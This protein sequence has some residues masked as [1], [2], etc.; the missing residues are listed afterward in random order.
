MRDIITVIKFFPVEIIVIM[1]VMG[2]GSGPGVWAGIPFGMQVILFGCLVIGLLRG[3]YALCRVG[4]D[5]EFA[6]SAAPDFESEADTVD[7]WK[8]V[9]DQ[10]VAAR[11]FPPESPTFTAD[12]LVSLSKLLDAVNVLCQDA[13][14]SEAEGHALP[15]GVRQT[16]ERVSVALTPECSDLRRLAA[17]LSRG[18][19]S[20]DSPMEYDPVWSPASP[21]PQWQAALLLADLT[22]AAQHLASLTTMLGLDGAN[23]FLAH[24]SKVDSIRNPYGLIEINPVTG[25]WPKVPPV[26]Y[27]QLVGA[28]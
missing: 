19:V 28:R 6:D 10:M 22:Q 18:V 26:D 9:Q 11:R 15:D 1:L 8:I 14:Y 12:A 16:L 2:I 24:A 5:E 21:M 17:L 7:P 27:S 4:P 23:A 3:V 25:A 13:L 20:D